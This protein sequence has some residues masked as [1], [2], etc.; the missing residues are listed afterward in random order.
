M[1][2]ITASGKCVNAEVKAYSF[3]AAEFWKLEK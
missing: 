2:S 1:A 3:G